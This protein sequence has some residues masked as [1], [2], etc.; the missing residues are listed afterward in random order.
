MP[1]VIDYLLFDEYTSD[2]SIGDIP[3]GGF[4]YNTTEDRLKQKVG[5]VS[6]TV[7][8]TY[9]VHEDIPLDS[10]VQAN[11][12]HSTTVSGNPHNLG[13]QEVGLGNV[14]NEP[15]LSR[16]PNDFGTFSPKVGVGSSDVILVEDA[17]DGGKKKKVQAS[18][19]LSGGF[20][21]D[22]IV[23]DNAGGIVYDN[24]DIAVRRA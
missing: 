24:D 3:E 21:I 22:N 11:L 9:A 14:D 7:I 5:T 15:Q 8:R 2:P 12:S 6:G 23:W 17:S 4:W 1:H 19:F 16:S 20:D 10:V 13:K 18:E